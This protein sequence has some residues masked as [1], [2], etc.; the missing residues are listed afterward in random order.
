MVEGGVFM[1]HDYNNASMPGVKWAVDQFQ[2][3]PYGPEYEFTDEADHRKMRKK[4]SP[5]H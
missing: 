5:E 2:Y 4:T 3:G 1:V